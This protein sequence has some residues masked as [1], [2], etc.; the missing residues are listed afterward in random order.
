MIY[1]SL[2]DGRRYIGKSDAQKMGYEQDKHP[3]NQKDISVVY[4]NSRLFLLLSLRGQ[5]HQGNYQKISLYHTLKAFSLF[6]WISTWGAYVVVTSWRLAFR[7]GW[8]LLR[9]RALAG[10]NFHQRK[11]LRS[12]LHV[13]ISPSKSRASLL[14][15]GRERHHGV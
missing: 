5:V 6:S 13:G 10:R 7:E 3:E 4:D 8:Y 15:H 11:I 12:N 9:I 2:H 1:T 14:L